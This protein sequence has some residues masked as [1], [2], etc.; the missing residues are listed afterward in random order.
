MP[1]IR[2]LDRS[3]SA[4]PAQPSAPAAPAAG[5]PAPPAPA[6]APQDAFGT[7][8]ATAASSTVDAVRDQAVAIRNRRSARTGADPATLTPIGKALNRALA[9]RI[10]QPD[11]VDALF[12]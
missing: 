4:R 7:A 8:R 6:P 9:D 3:S 12:K 11:E 5:T 2:P 1:D 10:L